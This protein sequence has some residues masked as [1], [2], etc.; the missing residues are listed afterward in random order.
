M[1]MEDKQEEKERSNNK[2]NCYECNGDGCSHC[3]QTGEICDDCRRP[4][5]ACSGICHGEEVMFL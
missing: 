4:W 5:F 1:R 3:R 2:V